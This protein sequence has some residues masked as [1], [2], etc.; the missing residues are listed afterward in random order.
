M[1]SSGS[2]GERR[3]MWRDAARPLLAA[4]LT[5]MASTSLAAGQDA[6]PPFPGPVRVSELARD[7]AG[8]AR[9]GVLSSRMIGGVWACPTRLQILVREGDEVREEA[10][11]LAWDEAHLPVRL[12]QPAGLFDSGSPLVLHDAER[13]LLLV[14]Y[15]RDATEGALLDSARVPSRRF[16]A[17]ELDWAWLAFRYAGFGLPSKPEPGFALEWFAVQPGHR[18]LVLRFGND[19]TWLDAR[20]AA[21]ALDAEELELVR[22]ALQ[23]PKLQD[24]ALHVLLAHGVPVDPAGI[25]DPTSRLCA[26]LARGEAQAQIELHELL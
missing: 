7:T 19:A 26:R 5:S 18:E 23:L 11:E 20:L 2:M 8:S 22:L 17:E 10:L 4:L 13:R 15:E 1:H 12:G 21:P 24:R 6:L 14:S 3:S 25:R 9:G 16:S